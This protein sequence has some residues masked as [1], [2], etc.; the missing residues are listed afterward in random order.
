[1]VDPVRCT[2]IAESVRTVVRGL[3]R[4]AAC[5][6][7][8]TTAISS[9]PALAGDRN[10]PVNVG[11]VVPQMS[12]GMRNSW[13][14]D[15]IVA[16]SIPAA[17][18][19][20]G[21]AG[22][23]PPSNGT[24]NIILL[25]SATAGVAPGSAPAVP[26]GS[27]TGVGMSKVEAG[28]SGPGSKALPVKAIENGP[29]MNPAVAASSDAAVSLITGANGKLVLAPGQSVEIADPRT[30]GLR[31]VITA[32]AHQ[33]LDISKIVAN[34]ER[35]GIYAAL[36]ARA[37]MPRANNVKLVSDGRVLLTSTGKHPSRDS[38]YRHRRKDDSER[39]IS[40][41]SGQVRASDAVKQEIGAD[42]DATS[43]TGD[44]VLS[45]TTKRDSHKS[46]VCS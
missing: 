37:D 31:V 14:Q 26:A 5:A 20:A 19:T 41:A 21:G 9:L 40:A 11:P 39:D 2:G 30:P 28:T 33:S 22:S 35:S 25:P 16:A 38:D 36:S 32:P 10:N 3:F 45:N 29:G 1:M 8:V 12:P 7:A 27:A 13:K 23:V 17:A 4:L 43:R 18:S 44:P 6:I 24:S 15:N 46:G 34:M 42:R